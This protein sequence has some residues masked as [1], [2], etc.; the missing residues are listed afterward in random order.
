MPRKKTSA[1]PV[2]TPERLEAFGREITAVGEEARAKLGAEDVAY[3][4]KMRKVSRAA[5]AVG[6]ALIH[7]SFDPFTW[8]AGVFALF[9]HK[10]LETT[11]IGHSALHGSWDGLAG[12]E[13]FYSSAFKWIFPVEEESWKREHNVLHH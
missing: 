8:S 5:E 12:A 10:Q 9:V 6:R 2:W 11:E 13:A 3:V 7:F 4:K 1:A